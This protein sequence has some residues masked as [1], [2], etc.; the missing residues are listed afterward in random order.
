MRKQPSAAGRKRELPPDVIEF[1]AR[2][3]WGR[4]AITDEIGVTDAEPTEQGERLLHLL[5][6]TDP[7]RASSVEQGRTHSPART[8]R[9][10]QSALATSV[11]VSAS[12]PVV[13][14]GQPQ[15][16]KEEGKAVKDYRRFPLRK[17][18]EEPLCRRLQ[19]LAP[20]AVGEQLATLDSEPELLAAVAAA[21]GV[22]AEPEVSFADALPRPELTDLTAR[23]WFDTRGR[24][25]Y[26]LSAPEPNGSRSYALAEV[27]AAVVAGRVARLR[28][29][30]LAMW[31]LRLLIDLGFYSIPLLPSPALVGQGDQMEAAFSR[32]LTLLLSIR[33]RFNE[34]QPEVALSRGFL[35]D[36]GGFWTL[37]VAV[38][39]GA[40]PA[41][42]ESRLRE[43]ARRLL[44]R[45]AA[46]GLI[47]CTG[48]APSRFGR[49]TRL[50]VRGESWR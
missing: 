40:S 19:S 3:G 9:D 12:V 33:E 37:P 45:Y 13:T 43:R 31:K 6:E 25:V 28:G 27:Y 20:Q 50:W 18:E 46:A 29:A 17:D 30:V 14:E 39:D 32:G 49:A 21:L 7:S 48:T 4:V 1:M 8:P 38:V 10:G 26:N 34:H 36:W 42:V 2:R 23:W 16:G 11:P 44:E 15:E 41:M 47:R 35:V 24:Y 22:T 5:Q